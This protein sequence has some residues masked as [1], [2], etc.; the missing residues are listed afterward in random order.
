[1]WKIK[2]EP[3]FIKSIIAGSLLSALTAKA[4]DDYLP[5][6]PNGLLDNFNT[7]IANIT[8]WLLSLIIMLSVL[9]IIYG[10]INYVGSTGDQE[11]AQKAK[12]MVTYSIMG[13]LIAGIAYAFVKVAVEQVLKS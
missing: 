10:G 7:G 4:A 11:R 2:L 5:V 12:K 3:I 1:M 9:V 13:L 6:K 8:E